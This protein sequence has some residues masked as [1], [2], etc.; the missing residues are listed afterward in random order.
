[1]KEI[2]CQILRILAISFSFFL[3][4][5][6]KKEGKLS[7]CPSCPFDSIQKDGQKLVFLFSPANKWPGEKEKETKSNQSVI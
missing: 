4:S 2:Y 7:A 6:R 3:N 5:K 1:M